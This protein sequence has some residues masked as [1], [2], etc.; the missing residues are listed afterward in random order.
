MIDTILHIQLNEK[1]KDVQTFFLHESLVVDN[2]INLDHFQSDSNRLEPLNCLR[3]RFRFHPFCN[4]SL[5]L[6]NLF[7]AT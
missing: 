2:A 4:F 7:L 3:F 5:A 1:L 6:R